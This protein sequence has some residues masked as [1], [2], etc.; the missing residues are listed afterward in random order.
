[1]IHR[2]EELERD[3]KDGMRRALA[4]ESAAYE[5]LLGTLASLVRGWLVN[6]GRSAEAAED[7][8]Q[9]VLIAVHRKKHLYDPARPFL[10][11]LF[12]VAR[13]RVIDVARAQARR[14][15]TV[16]LED[17]FDPAAPEDKTLERTL[18]VEEL[19]DALPER[20]RRVLSLA[21]IDGLPL[22]DVGRRLGMS[23]AAVKV[24]VHRAVKKLKETFS[25]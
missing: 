8:V 25:P 3:L 4:G 5:T 23:T 22:E 11:W 17:L 18:L 15:S 12:A 2:R 7:L 10:P 6:Q 16:P 14:P 20:Q 21:K 13:Y 19:L 9:D 1:M 24:T